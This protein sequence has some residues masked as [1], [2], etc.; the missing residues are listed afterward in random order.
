MPRVNL[1]VEIFAN[2]PSFRSSIEC[3]VGGG[4]LSDGGDV[5][6]HRQD[7]GIQ[8]GRVYSVVVAVDVGVFE[9]HH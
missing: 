1:V 3:E 6:W 2:K 4:Q 9:P 7:E 5:I 8:L